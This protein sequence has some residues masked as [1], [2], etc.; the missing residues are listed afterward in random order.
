M[1]LEP[2]TKALTAYKS[3][4]CHLCFNIMES[5]EFKIVSLS[6]DPEVSP[7]SSPVSISM[8]FSSPHI[9][10]SAT[11][12]VFY[13]IDTIRKRKQYE[14]LS[15][16]PQ[17]FSAGCNTLAF[18]IPSIEVENTSSITAGVLLLTLSSSSEELLGINMIV[19]IIQKEGAYSKTIFS[20]LE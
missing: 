5:E 11:W 20:P 6:I 15:L 8:V 2:E 7:L 19:Q 9:L 12:K 3:F 4:T 18:T 16:P 1:L 13:Q 14:I 10:S 17:D